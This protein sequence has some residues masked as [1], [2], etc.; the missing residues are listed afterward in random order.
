MNPYPVRPIAALKRK[1]MF[2]TQ[3]CGVSSS[4]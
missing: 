1:R 3:I 2:S 4:R